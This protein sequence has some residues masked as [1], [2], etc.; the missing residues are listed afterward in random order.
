MRNPTSLNDKLFKTLFEVSGDAY[1]L[2]QNGKFIEFNNS[3][4]KMLCAKREEMLG[5][6]PVDISPN[7]QMD[8]RRSD[9]K[10]E[11]MIKIALKNGTHKFEWTHRRMNG[12]LFPAEIVLTALPSIENDSM[13]LV[14]WRDISERRRLEKNNLKMLE[15]IKLLTDSSHIGI[16]EFNLTDNEMSWNDAMYSIFNVAKEVEQKDLINAWRKNVAPEDVE[17]LERVL[18]VMKASSLRFDTDFSVVQKDGSFKYYRIFANGI[19]MDGNKES[20]I[21]ICLDNTERAESVQ[22]LHEE[23]DTAELELMEATKANMAKSM[24]LANMSH[25]IRTPMNGII[26]FLELLKQTPLNLSLIHI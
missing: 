7:T 22:K 16:W 21:G 9:E 18:E 19:M 10:A 4:L 2:L 24:F 23:R 26:G 25:E 15:K 13:M 14:A 5:I 8:G 11:E 20:I 17:K 6:T 3:S 12:E 1:V